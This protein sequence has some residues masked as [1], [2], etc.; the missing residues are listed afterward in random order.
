MKPFKYIE[1][2]GGPRKRNLCC[3]RGGNKPPPAF[4]P[5]LRRISE[6]VPL[7]LL[8]R[9]S[10]KPSRIEQLPRAL[11]EQASRCCFQGSFFGWGSL[12]CQKRV[13]AQPA[14]K[15]LFLESEFGSQLC[16]SSACELPHGSSLPTCRA[17]TGIPPWQGRGT[18]CGEYLCGV[19]LVC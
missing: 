17:R 6:A 8:G 7:S 5:V 19:A 16:H 2:W 3:S 18:G 11:K 1:R 9:A 4:E 14:V 13:A 12:C 10:Q 15:N